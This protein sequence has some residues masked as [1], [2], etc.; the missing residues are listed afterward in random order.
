MTG[1]K[2][3]MA[4]AHDV[5]EERV[6][7]STRFLSPTVGRLYRWWASS[8]APPRRAD[9]DIADHW[10]LAPHLFL[11]AVLP[12][13]AFQFRLYGERV[14]KIL[15]VNN[16]GRLITP[17]GSDNAEGDRDL[18]RYYQR[19]AAERICWRCVGHFGHRGREHIRFESIDCPL[20]AEDGRIVAIIGC[21]DELPRGSDQD[22]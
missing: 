10:R 11:V 13:D 14:I 22:R 5:V 15:G 21:M 17:G 7:E 4:P 1:G 2:A 6:G 12:D 19:I 9:F 20:A 16:R 3:H 18:L 8:G